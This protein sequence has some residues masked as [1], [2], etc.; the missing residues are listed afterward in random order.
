[1]RNKYP[2]PRID[3]LFDQL[4]GAQV[5]SKIDLRFGY[6]QLKIKSE[7]IPKT[8]FRTRYGHYEFL[9]MP[10]GLTNTPAA[11]MDLMNRVFH[12][13]L[14]RFVIVFID[15]ILIFSKSMEE[16]EEHLRIV[17]QILREKKLYAKFKKC[18]FWLDQV[19]F[20]GKTNKYE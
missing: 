16:H 5:F 7:D 6:H 11:F 12:E 13:Y 14:D 15:D 19:V 8:A 10:F 1:M 17:F 9:V 18:E 4:Q 2:F 3:D 20:L